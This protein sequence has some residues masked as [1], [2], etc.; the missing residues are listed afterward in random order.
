MSRFILV[1]RIIQE[2]EVP[3]WINTDRIEA[4]DATHGGGNTRLQLGLS[5]VCTVSESVTAVLDAIRRAE[6]DR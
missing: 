3:T 4:L 6:D 1:H 2:G 5:G